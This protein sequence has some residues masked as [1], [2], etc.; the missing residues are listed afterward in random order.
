MA[1]PPGKQLLCSTRA[2]R[3]KILRQGRLFAPSRS[4]RNYRWHQILNS[5]TDA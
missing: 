5:K 3:Q 2:F 4:T 1:P